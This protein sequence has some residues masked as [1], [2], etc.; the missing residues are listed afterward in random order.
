MNLIFL[1]SVGDQNNKATKL[2]DMKASETDTCE[3]ED[4]EDEGK[5]KK[6]KKNKNKKST[7]NQK[8][9]AGVVEEGRSRTPGSGTSTPGK[10]LSKKSPVDVTGIILFVQYF[11]AVDQYEMFYLT[12]LFQLTYFLKVPRFLLHRWAAIRTRS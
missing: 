2:G 11:N 10:D 4:D 5:K 8:S 9:R 6:K 7:S 1:Q 3:E 12:S